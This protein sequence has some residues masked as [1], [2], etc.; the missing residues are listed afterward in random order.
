MSNLHYRS[1]G[2]EICIVCIE[3]TGIVSLTHMIETCCV[4]DQ[5]YEEMAVSL[6]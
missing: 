4:G 2:V 1:F 5:G 3:L 6:N